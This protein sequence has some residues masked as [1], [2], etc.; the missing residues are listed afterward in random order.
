MEVTA[1]KQV[2][3]MRHQIANV[4]HDLK[5]PLSGF[6]GG[7][8]VTNGLIMELVQKFKASPTIPTLD[9]KDLLESIQTIQSYLNNAKM[10]LV[11]HAGLPN[12]NRNSIHHKVAK[13]GRY[14]PTEEN[15]TH[16]NSQRTSKMDDNSTSHNFGA[17]LNFSIFGSKMKITPTK[18]YVVRDAKDIEANLFSGSCED[19]ANDRIKFSTNENV[20]LPSPRMRHIGKI[21]YAGAAHGPHYTKRFCVGRSL[22]NQEE[23]RSGYGSHESTPKHSHNNNVFE[24]NEKHVLIENNSSIRNLNSVKFSSHNSQIFHANDASTVNENPTT[25][26]ST[27]AIDVLFEQPNGFT[28]SHP[29]SIGAF[30]NN[31]GTAIVK[32]TSTQNETIC[33]PIP[34]DIEYKE[35][36][37]RRVLIVDDSVSIVKMTGLR[38]KQLGYVT[39]QASNGSDA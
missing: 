2:S 33:E 24:P 17:S 23:N 9:L 36:K 34:I 20:P 3:E 7:L 25:T 8:D 38:L 14:I 22:S 4:A 37:K 29:P 30:H 28:L 11:S 6:M 32:T 31:N 15:S 19:T 27:A 1:E 39:E 35:P 26:S 10:T 21:E 5:T 18:D 13:E 12:E 16:N